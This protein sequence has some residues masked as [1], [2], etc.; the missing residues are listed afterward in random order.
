[1]EF[2]FFRHTRNNLNNMNQMKLNWTRVTSEGIPGKF[3]L[4]KSQ[5]LQDTL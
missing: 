4:F 3:E 2:G 1:M 5:C